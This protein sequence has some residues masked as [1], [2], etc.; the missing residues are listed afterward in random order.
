MTMR[1]TS[2]MMHRQPPQHYHPSTTTSSSSRY[3]IDQLYNRRTLWTTTSSLSLL[4][5]SLSD[6]LSWLSTHSLVHSEKNNDD[7]SMAHR[8][9]HSLRPPQRFVD[10]KHW[11]S[12]M[13]TT[14]TPTN[15]TT[16]T[17]TTTTRIPNRTPPHRRKQYRIPQK[18]RNNDHYS[19]E[20]WDGLFRPGMTAPLKIKLNNYATSSSS[21]NRTGISPTQIVV[22]DDET[23]LAT[24]TTQMT[25]LLLDYPN[26]N[27]HRR[28]DVRDALRT[29]PDM[30]SLLS[31]LEHLLQLP[32]QE[33]SGKNDNSTTSHCS[34]SVDTKQSSHQNI[35]YDIFKNVKM[36]SL[37]KLRVEIEEYIDRYEMLKLDRFLDQND[38]NDDT[39]KQEA[40]QQKDAEC[41]IMKRWT[42]LFVAVMLHSISNC[43]VARRIHP[44]DVTMALIKVSTVHVDLPD[45]YN[46]HFNPFTGKDHRVYGVYLNDSMVKTTTRDPLIPSRII[47]SSPQES[48]AVNEPIVVLCVSL[49][50]KIP[51][52]LREIFC[53]APKTSFTT[54]KHATSDT[55]SSSI[56]RPV[57]T[58]YSILNVQHQ[59]YSKLKLGEY[60]I[61]ESVKMLQAES[62]STSSTSTQDNHDDIIRVRNVTTTTAVESA[63]STPI[64]TFVTLSPIPGFCTWVLNE[65]DICHMYCDP[66]YFY[67]ASTGQG[68][69]RRKPALYHTVQFLSRQWM[70]PEE[71]VVMKITDYLYARSER[72]R[73]KEKNKSQR[74]KLNIPSIPIDGIETP[75]TMSPNSSPQIQAAMRYFLEG[76]A[77]HYIVHAKI[78]DTN[79]TTTMSTTTDTNKPTNGVARFHLQN[80]AEVYRINAFADLSLTGINSSLGVMVNYRYNLSQL[81]YN[82]SQYEK[83]YT[84]AIHDYVKQQLQ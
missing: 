75:Q 48:D 24:Y 29:H 72:E 61:H 53:A 14:T 58:F 63:V 40:F 81:Q 44:T 62:S 19:V 41:S 32:L 57:A 15:N 50:P 25:N 18:R 71:E 16:T 66:E 27:I 73:Q 64:D 5:S 51:R 37:L 2:R 1:I 47:E 36:E 83:N 43:V 10:R 13:T 39:A 45:H 6:T 77:A 8:P 78:S 46:D 3:R 54:P 34:D 59:Q 11:N 28:E 9:Y 31:S 52:S 7:N 17:T 35:F 70:C 55:G 60:L 69:I 21:G 20:G 76:M 82:Q 80:G 26:K 23:I 84:V 68:I 4:S 12:S 65:M 33:E 49:Q 74:K 42:D 56:P 67:D 79:G 30:I 22:D 38:L